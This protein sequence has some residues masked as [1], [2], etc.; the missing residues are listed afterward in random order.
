MTREQ[1]KSLL[2]TYRYSDYKN[3]YEKY[4]DWLVTEKVEQSVKFPEKKGE[5][6][7]FQFRCNEEISFNNEQRNNDL[8]VLGEIV[9]LENSIS[10]Y[11]FDVTTD[12]K[13]KVNGI[14]HTCEQIY[15]GNVGRHRGNTNRPCIRSDFGF[16]TWYNR[17]NSQGEIKDLNKSDKFTS[18]AVHM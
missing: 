4:K 13:S 16:G 18:I 14:A 12:P 8:L 2:T 11:M 17:T 1:I 7:V 9:D 15:R 3:L 10:D 6:F 5:I